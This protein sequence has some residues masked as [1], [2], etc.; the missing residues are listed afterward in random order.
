MEGSARDDDDVFEVS[1]SA[2]TAAAEPEFQGANVCRVAALSTMLGGDRR[3]VRGLAAPLSELGFPENLSSGEQVWSD[4]DPMESFAGVRDQRFDGDIP[5]GDRVSYWQRIQETAEPAAAIAFLVAVLGSPLERESAAAASALWRQ[6]S[7]IDPQRLRRGPPWPYWRGRLYDVLGPEWD[8]PAW[9]GFPWAQRGVL[10]IDTDIEDSSEVAWEPET[11]IAIYARTIS[12]LGD[13]YGDIWLIGLLV[14]WRLSRA[15][16]SPDPI[17]RSLAQAAFWPSAELGV[18]DIPPPAA[19]S[20]IPAE[21]VV[22][23]TMIHGTWAWTGDWW[24]PGGGFHKFICDNYRSNL[25]N[26][27][28]FFT[29]SGAYRPGHRKRAAERLYK[30]AGADGRGGLETV[31]AHSYGGDVAAAAVAIHR[32]RVNELVLLSAPATEYVEAAA[33]TGMRIVDVRLYFDPVLGLARRWQRIE[34]GPKVKQVI[35]KKWRLDHG[36]THRDRV[37]RKEDVAKRGGIS[38]T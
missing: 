4:V 1:P 22:V 29:W 6:V 36:A 10:D 18:A 33:R 13:R 8:E 5:G 11:W 15:L 16:R 9:W 30:W 20:A 24:E 14:R 26:E 32:T 34:K 28:A 37:W 35:L 7:G 27:G 23:S 25:Y 12:R 21:G 2:D 3:S 17:T 31:F 38:A 19:P